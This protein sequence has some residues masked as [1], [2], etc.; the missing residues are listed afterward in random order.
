MNAQLSEALEA[1]QVG[2]Y[3]YL[4]HLIEEGL[5]VN[6][7]YKGNA[8]L[9]QYALTFESLKCFEVLL[10]HGADPEKEV[11]GWSP[12]NMAID[13]EITSSTDDTWE[14]GIRDKNKMMPNPVFT[15]CLIRPFSESLFVY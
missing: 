12:L 6:S 4:E 13:S 14:Y 11:D 10:R 1:I 2:D 5:G 3:E 7:I 15:S 9:L 8:H